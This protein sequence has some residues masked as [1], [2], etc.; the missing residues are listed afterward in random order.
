MKRLGFD[1]RVALCV[2]GFILA[3]IL[4]AVDEIFDIPHRVFG[5]PPTPLNW[6]ELMT[7]TAYI[8]VVGLLTVFLLLQLVSKRK[9]AERMLSTILDAMEDGVY[10][11]NT[12]HEV[13]YTNQ[14]MLT[15]FGPVQGRK[16]YQYLHDREEPCPW[17]KIEAVL[18]GESIRRNRY[19]LKNQ[20]TYDYIGTPFKSAD[21]SVSKL[22]ILRDMTER[23]RLEWDIAKLKELDKTK[24]NLL[25]TVSHELRSPLATIKGYT[26][27]LVDSHRKLSDS[28]KREF[29]LAIQKDAERLAD[30][31]SNLLDLSRL[32]AGLV[33]LEMNLC[34]IGTVLK[35]VVAAAR[36]RSPGH[37]IVLKVAEGLPRVN[38]DVARIE[39]VLHNLIDNATKYSVERTEITVTAKK[40]DNELFI[41]V[42]DQGVGIPA[43]EL[44]KVFY[45]MYRIERK[46]NKAPEGIGLGLSLCK[47]L[48][49]LHGGRIWVESEVGVGSTFWF[50]LPVDRST[51]NSAPVLADVGLAA[52][53]AGIVNR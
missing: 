29:I 14:A 21:G 22:G 40:V 15:Q 19:S 8:F 28:Q 47:G 16:C 10:I 38:V 3:D 17:C 41:S 9:R 45:P 4:V 31:V 51:S 13:T 27:M 50:T 42:S 12:N 2:A 23:T 33:K 44:E 36:I 43:G 24:R 1:P 30:L 5:A 53:D 52:H 7:E 25:S 11:V 35:R 18:E 39:Q 48:V 46:D 6:T 49:A 32:E 26:S 20:R 34:S 37:R